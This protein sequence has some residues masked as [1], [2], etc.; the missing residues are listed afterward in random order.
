[1]K[2]RPHRSPNKAAGGESEEEDFTTNSVNMGSVYRSDNNTKKSIVAQ[3]V[4]KDGYLQPKAQ[5]VKKRKTPE[6]GI[7]ISKRNQSH[8]AAEESLKV[9]K[10]LY[11]AD[12]PPWS[13][14]YP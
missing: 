8:I 12:I 7:D 10:L 1:M 6:A 5:L 3:M 11:E 4:V 13:L 9:E 14:H 2:R